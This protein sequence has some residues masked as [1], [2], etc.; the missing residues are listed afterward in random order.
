MIFRMWSLLTMSFTIAC[1]G[2]QSQATGPEPPPVVVPAPEGPVVRQPDNYSAT[3]TVDASALRQE[4][5]GFGSSMRIFSDPHLIGASG[6][7]ENSLQTTRA[8]EQS[9]LELLYNKI[10]L[11]RVR[12]TFQARF[13][14]P[15]P[16]DVPRT[17]WIFADGPIDLVKRAQP[18]GLQ[19]WWLSPGDLE[20]WMNDS[21]VWEYAEWAMRIIRY[22]KAQGTELTWYS[23]IN[24]PGNLEVRVSGEF[25][26]D[27]VKMIG[28]K[29]AAE[30]FKTRLVIPDDVNPASGAP[31]ARTVLADPEARKYVGAIAVHIYGV[32]VSTMAEMAE[33]A[34]E[35]KLPLWM[36]EFSAGNSRLDWALLI[37]ALI[38]D[39]N[40]SAVDHMWGFFGTGERGAQLVSIETS[41]RKFAGATITPAGFAT[42]QYA[43]FVRPGAR[44]V[45]AV[46]SDPGVR[47]TAFVRDGKVTIVAINE[48]GSRQAVRFSI[49]G[50]PAV[51]SVN[52]IRTSAEEQLAAVGRVLV[53][54]G[55]FKLELPAKS[56]S[57]LTQ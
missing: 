32:P 54:S 47:V 13:T 15:T 55:S 14:Q 12:A 49:S 16:Y 51:Q 1:D 30:G 34:N 44:R 57:T 50:A 36:S 20:T 23:I 46:S 39:Y 21:T 19:E 29:L 24:E 37:H 18:V 3:V 53:T 5:A 38:A 28:P 48:G 10:G 43:R 41:G 26:R 42:A 45:H 25:V 17:D 56:I 2:G 7:I 52:L 22:W 40:V 6:G 9:V 31:I 11:T 33:I 27:A 35:Y 8:E 4:I